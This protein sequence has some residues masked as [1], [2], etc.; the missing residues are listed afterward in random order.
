MNHKESILNLAKNI[1]LNYVN[2]GEKLYTAMMEMAK[3]EKRDFTSSIW[4]SLYYQISF[5]NH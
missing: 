2:L 5:C 4:V 1:D 3:L